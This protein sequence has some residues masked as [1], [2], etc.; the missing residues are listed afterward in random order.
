VATAVV[1]SGVLILVVLPLLL[2]SSKDEKIEVRARPIMVTFPAPYYGTITGY[3][4]FIIYND[5][6][7]KQFICEALPVN[8]NTGQIPSESALVSNPNG[9]LTKGYCQPY[10]SGTS[11]NAL[12]VTIA[13]KTRA[14]EAYSCFLQET[15]VFNK[16]NIPYYL[17]TGPNSNSYVRTMLDHCGLPAVKP[18]AA[19]LTP[20][21]DMSISL[22]G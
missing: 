17:T 22:N 11:T 7:G 13:T 20:G 6:V 4:L 18:P 9:L 2:S 14:K 12:S 8:S 15:Q 16:A 21:W 1:V 10:F 19:V 3:H 5:S